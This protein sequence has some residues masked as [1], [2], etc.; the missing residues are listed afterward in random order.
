M[1]LFYLSKGK[2]NVIY[3]LCHKSHLFNHLDVGEYSFKILLN[4]CCES[5][6]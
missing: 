2:D 4:Y 3:Q 6:K 1:W 5:R